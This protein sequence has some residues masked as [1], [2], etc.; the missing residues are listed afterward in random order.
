MK[1]VAVLGL[2]VGL[3]RVG[4]AGCDGLG[5][6]ATELTTVTRTSFKNDV[7][8]F[9]QIVN[10][11]EATLLVVGMPYTMNGEMGFQAKQVMKYAKRLSNALGLPLDFVDERLTSIEA[12]EQLRESKKFSHYNKGLIDKRAAAI[13]LQQWLDDN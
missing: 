1:R 7:E 5:L 6:L 13:I 12:E 11:R 2:D 3:R 4:V 10:E 9:R 8:V